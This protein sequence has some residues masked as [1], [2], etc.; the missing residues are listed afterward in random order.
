MTKGF[1]KDAKSN[2][3]TDEGLIEAIKEIEQGLTGDALGG[4]LFKKRVAIGS[5]GKSG[6]LRTIVAYKT[7]TNN[8]FCIYVFA[9]KQ[10]DNIEDDE[11]TALRRLGKVY[12][13]MTDKQIKKAITEKRLQEVNADADNENDEESQA[14]DSAG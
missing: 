12:L 14:E 8:I 13:E 1:A 11:L 9:K 3:L 7:S 6:G 2:G 4:N 10:R 5:K